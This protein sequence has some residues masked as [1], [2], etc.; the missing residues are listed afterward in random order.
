MQYQAESGAIR[1]VLTGDSLITRPMRPFA[2]PGFLDLLEILRGADVAVTNVEMLF[3]DLEHSPTAVPGGTYMHAS[4]QIIEELQWMG[5]NLAASANNHAYDYGENGLVTHLGHLERS[6]LVHA[7]I[8]RT[9]GEAR[10][11]RYLDTPAGRVALISVTSSGPPGLMA[12]H[13]WRDGLGRPGANMIRYT[14][15]YTVDQPTFAALKTLRDRFDL[16]RVVRDARRGFANHSW[17]MSGQPDTETEFYLGDLHDEWQ[18]A[19]PNGYRFALGDDFVRELVPYAPDMEENLQ[20]IRDAR[21]SADWVIVTMHNHEHGVTLDDPSDVAVTF[22]HAAIDA[23]AD[24]FHGHGPH[25]DRGVEIYRGKPIFYSLGHLILQNDTVDRMPA[26]NMQRQ[27]LDPYTAT[28]ADFFDARSGREWAGEWVAAS[29][30]R[31]RWEDAVG[32]V[33][34]AGGKLSGVTLQPIDLGFRRPRYMRGRPV[35][36]EDDVAQNVLGLFQQLSQPFGTEIDVV[37]NLGHVRLDS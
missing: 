30:T 18:Y 10:S 25:R 4:P 32:V 15:R 36:A 28:P 2:E 31:S 6:G 23:G 22:A 37:G 1:M 29:D 9:L 8:G 13:Q 21:R 11:P 26:E 16:N 12:A 17:G 7:G 33:E 24:V 20:R 14:T 35:L 27:G 5:I 19:V 34:F 3:H